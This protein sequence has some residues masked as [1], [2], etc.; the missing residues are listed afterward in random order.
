METHF[1]ILHLFKCPKNNNE[2][3]PQGMAA[4]VERLAFESNR[5]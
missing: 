3:T 2:I 1:S 4:H 5:V